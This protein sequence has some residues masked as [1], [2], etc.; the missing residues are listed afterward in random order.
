MGLFMPTSTFDFL[1]HLEKNKQAG[2][3][4]TVSTWFGWKQVE[5]VGTVFTCFE[6]T[7]NSWHFGKMVKASRLLK[8]GYQLLNTVQV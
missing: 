4:G 3:V 5:T 2:T 7:H 6:N 8:I 1:A